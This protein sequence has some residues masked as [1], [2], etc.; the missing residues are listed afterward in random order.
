MIRAADGDQR[1]GIIS[2][3]CHAGPDRIA[4]FEFYTPVAHREALG[5]YVRACAE[6]FDAAHAETGLGRGRG[7][8]L[9]RDDQG[10]WDMARRT[11]HMEA[12]GIVAEIIFPKARSPS[13]NTRRSG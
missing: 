10:L 8:A 3:D 9:N 12:D 6:A 7:G 1:V 13:L 2:A 11:Q 5:D 4:D